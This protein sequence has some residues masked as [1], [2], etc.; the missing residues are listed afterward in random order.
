MASAAARVSMDDV[1][2]QVKRMQNEGERL[3]ARLR[4][5]AK[6]LL[7]STRQQVVTDLLADARKLQMDV[8]KRV[9]AA[10]KDLDVRRSRLLAEVEE[11]A[12]KLVETLVKRLRVASAED[13][14][15]L[16]TRIDALEKQVHQLGR[17][18]SSLLKEKAK[19]EKAA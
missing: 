11:Q 6:G 12:T 1:R 18:L 19:S 2:A 7:S 13:I 14:G 5:D 3:V 15:S 16:R 17:E 9:D 4:R 8:R 10:L